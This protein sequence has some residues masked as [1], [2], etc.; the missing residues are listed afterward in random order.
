MDM[1]C[2]RLRYFIELSGKLGIYWEPWHGGGCYR[3]PREDRY[4]NI[5]RATIRRPSS[6]RR[7]EKQR[8]STAR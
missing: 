2:E 1:R 4:K 6:L 3:Q 7:R 8:T 5:E